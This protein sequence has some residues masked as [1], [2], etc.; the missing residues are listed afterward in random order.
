MFEFANAW[1]FALLVVIALFAVRVRAC[2]DV[3]DDF[4][5]DDQ[6]WPRHYRALPSSSQM[7]WL[8]KHWSRWTKA[9]WMAYTQEQKNEL[10]LRSQLKPRVY[11]ST[12]EGWHCLLQ[13]GCYR[14][15][16]VVRFIPHNSDGYQGWG[17]S[18][19][20]AYENWLYRGDAE[21]SAFRIEKKETA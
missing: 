2:F 13:S 20:S 21:R 4:L 11:K 5:D 14:G 3:K 9:Q 8:P 6:L 12:Y 19:K 7:V 17:P 10:I 15:R 16:S 1:P 18:P